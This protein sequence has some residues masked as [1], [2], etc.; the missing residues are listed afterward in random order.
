[1]GIYLTKK[2]YWNVSLEFLQF[3]IHLIVNLIHDSVSYL[4]VS[5]SKGIWNVIEKSVKTPFCI[6]EAERLK[7]G[8]LKNRPYIV[9]CIVRTCM[10]VF[11]FPSGHAW[12]KSCTT[13]KQDKIGLLRKERFQHVRV[14]NEWECSL[15]RPIVAIEK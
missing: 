2:I 12:L 1:M 9:S 14:A 11:F 5:N 8:V 10:Y 3:Q 4:H 13:M 7:K 6:Q 15:A